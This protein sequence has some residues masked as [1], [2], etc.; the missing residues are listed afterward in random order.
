WIAAFPPG[1]SPPARS[2]S[3]SPWPR[4]RGSGPPAGSCWSSARAGARCAGANERGSAG[5]RR[6]WSSTPPRSPPPT[7][8]ATSWAPGLPSRSSPARSGWGRGLAPTWHPRD[9]ARPR[10]G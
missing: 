10:S 2:R 9:A 6:S 5:P 1:P 3:A 7:C 4:P 8:S